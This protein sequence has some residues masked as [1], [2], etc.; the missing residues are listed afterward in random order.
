MLPPL[1]PKNTGSSLPPLPPKK[2]EG[3]ELSSINLPAGSPV[4]GS[5][6]PSTDYKKLSSELTAKNNNLNWVKRVT[7]ND[8]RFIQEP[9]GSKATH[10]L[11]WAEADGKI[12]VY[13][14]IVED[15]NGLKQLDEGEAFDYALSTKT[16]MEVPSKDIAQ[17]YSANGLIDHT[18]TP[19]TESPFKFSDNK[20]TTE[21]TTP[22]EAGST[23]VV[24][25]R[26]GDIAVMKQE[27]VKNDYLT[28]TALKYL[29]T[30]P[31]LSSISPDKLKQIKDQAINLGIP[32]DKIDEIY[33]IAVDKQRREAGLTKLSDK[34]DEITTRIKKGTGDYDILP[35]PGSN[36][37]PLGITP[38]KPT[39]EMVDK[40]LT[41]Y[42]T[43]IAIYE[44]P[45][46]KELYYINKEIERIE[47]DIN[48]TA[49][50]YRRRLYLVKQRQEL[51]GGARLFNPITGNFEDEPN[52]D[53]EK[54]AA[55]VDA[56]SEQLKRTPREKIGEKFFIEA[57]L[58][59]D[60][61]NQY[62][63]TREY[64]PEE[65]IKLGLGNYQEPRI[66]SLKDI[67]GIY[68]TIGM[69][70]TRMYKGKQEEE[71]YA[72]VNATHNEFVQSRKNLDALTDAYLL[73]ID[74]G[75]GNLG[76]L[77]YAG[78]GFLEGLE[79]S[80]IIG[81]IVKSVFGNPEMTDVQ[82]LETYATMA[83]EAGV[84]LTETQKK[85]VEN[86][87]TETV[88]RSGAASGPMMGDIVLS[89]IMLNA[90]GGTAALEAG[91]AKLALNATKNYGAIAGAATKILGEGVKTAITFEIAGAGGTTGVGE[92]IAQG[93]LDK[94][95]VLDK[96]TGK[97]GTLI[98]TLIKTGAGGLGETFG[99]YAGEFANA[100]EKNG[101]DYDKV[102]DDTFGK[103]LDEATKKGLA[104]LITSLLFSGTSNSTTAVWVAGKEWLNNQDIPNKDE[105]LAEIDKKI[106][107]GEATPPADI[108]ADV[109]PVDAPVAGG[110][111]SKNISDGIREILKDDYRYFEQLL[112]SEDEQE[113]S[114]ARRFLEDPKGYLGRRI[115][116]FTRYAEEAQSQS[117][118][119]MRDYYNG[120]VK[121]DKKKLS[122]INDISA[123]APAADGGVVLTPTEEI[124]NK[125][126]E[127]TTQEDTK[128]LA[129]D[130][131]FSDLPKEEKQVLLNE[132]LTKQE[133]ILQSQPV[134]EDGAVD[135]PAPI[136]E[137]VAPVE[138]VKPIRRLSTG[139]NVYF[140]TDKHRVNDD[141]KTGEVILNVGSKENTFP[142][143][144]IPFNDAADAVKIAERVARDF[145]NGVP[146]VILID[147]YIDGLKKELIGVT[148]VETPI[149]EAPVVEDG[150]VDIPAPMVE[151]VVKNTS[152]KIEEQKQK[153]LE[154]KIREL[155]DKRR[156][157]R[158]ADGSIPSD[159]MSEFK[160]LGTEINNAKK[161]AERGN[162]T[163]SMVIRVLP[164]NADF[165]T[166]DAEILSPSD[167]AKAADIIEQ[168]IQNS[169]TSDEA[170]EEIQ[171]L[172][173]VFNTNDAQHLKNYLDDRFNSK[174]PK[175]GNNK[176]SF[177]SWIYGK[178][179]TKSTEIAPA[180]TQPIETAPIKDNRVAT[181][182]PTQEPV[183]ENKYSKLSDQEIENRMGELENSNNPSDRQEFSVLEKEMEQR[184]WYS[185]MNK[186]LS[187]ADAAIDLLLQK[188]K[189]MPNGF[190][191]FI[192]KRDAS[193][194]KGVIKKYSSPDKI[195]NK[196]VLF[197]IYESM[198]ANP[199]T[200]YA[201]A[202]KLRESILLAIER[203]ATIEEIKNRLVT[204]LSN[205][206][207]MTIGMA[208]TI[209][210]ARIGPVLSAL[211]NE[212]TATTKA[213][214]IET[215]PVVEPAPVVETTPTK[216]PIPIGQKLE[217]R[218]TENGPRLMNRETGK[219]ADLGSVRTYEDA[220]IEA[221]K[222]DWINEGV[223][224]EE[225]QNRAA[226]FNDV[227]SNSTNPF[228]IAEAFV[229]SEAFPFE[230]RG[231]Y[232]DDFIADQLNGSVINKQSFIDYA[233][234]SHVAGLSKPSPKSK[235]PGFVFTEERIKGTDI[236]SF[237]ESATNISGVEITEEDVV[238]FMTTYGSVEAYLEQKKNPNAK[239]LQQKFK[240]LTGMP[241]N[242]KLAEKLAAQ[243]LENRG[244]ALAKQ[245]QL[246]LESEATNYEQTKQDLETYLDNNPDEAERVYAGEPITGKTIQ[247]EVSNVSEQSNEGTKG[248]GTEEVSYAEQTK[249]LA[250]EIKRRIKIDTKGTAGINI[251]PAVWN[252]AVDI[253]AS[254][255]ENGGKIADAIVKGIDY[256]KQTSAYKNATAAD[257]KS[258]EAQFKEAFGVF[259]DVKIPKNTRLTIDRNTG[260][261]RDNRA[262][263]DELKKQIR[264]SASV[265]KQVLSTEKER[266]SE[267]RNKVKEI[268]TNS[269]P[270]LPFISKKEIAKLFDRVAS[271][272]KD[273]DIDKLIN[274]ID[275][276]DRKSKE[277]EIKIDDADMAG[278][279]R[280]IKRD[281]K[282]AAQGF[283]QGISDTKKAGKEF[284]A[285][286]AEA[287]KPLGSKLNPS[288]I[289]A[290][291]RRAGDVSTERQLEKFQEYAEK[292]IAD[293]NYADNL[294][295]IAKAIKQLKRNVRDRNSIKIKE[296]AKLDLTELTVQQIS[297]L[298]DVL[299]AA[300]QRVPDTSLLEAYD[301]PV[302]NKPP[303]Q[304]KSMD[305]Y[306]E[307]RD[308]ILSARVYDLD[309]VR[310]VVRKLNTARRMLDMMLAQGMIS[311]AEYDSEMKILD[312]TQNL[313]S[314]MFKQDVDNA[315]RLAVNNIQT[316]LKDNWDK[317]NFT[318][319][320]NDFIGK[321]KSLTGDEMFNL[322]IGD[323]DALSD[324]S[325][326]IA[327]GTIPLNIAT[328][329]YGRAIGKARGAKVAEQVNEAAKK[330]IIPSDGQISETGGTAKEL[331]RAEAQ[332]VED[333]LNL[334]RG[335]AIYSYLYNVFSRAATA[336]MR[337]N[338]ALFKKYKDVAGEEGITSK[339]ILKV[340]S[341]VGAGTK[342]PKFVKKRILQ[343]SKVMMVRYASMVR[344]TKGSI[345]GFEI[346]SID[347][348]GLLL[349]NEAAYD[350]LIPTDGNNDVE[351]AKQ[352]IRDR[353]EEQIG[354]Y[355]TKR[356]GKIDGISQLD[357]MREVYE[358]FPKKSDGSVDWNAITLTPQE[359]KIAD[360][361]SEI[362][363]ELR[364][365]QR[366]AN[367]AKG[368]PFE[369]QFDYIKTDWLKRDSD[370]SSAE[371]SGKEG[372]R[373]GSSYV[374]TDFRPG[375][376]NINL[377][378]LMANSI[379][380]TNK[381][382]HF[383]NADMEIKPTLA[384]AGE[385]ITSK[386]AK[387]VV[388]V[389]LKQDL[390]ARKDFF[391]SKFSVHPY[392]RRL[393]NAGYIG[394][395]VNI[396]TRA[397][398][399]LVSTDK[400]PLLLGSLKPLKAIFSPLQRK[401]FAKLI[402]M[403]NS[404]LGTKLS[405][406]KDPSFEG[407]RS[408]PNLFER[409]TNSIISVDETINLV[410]A[411]MP[412]FT[413]EFASLAGEEFDMN[414]FVSDPDYAE[415]FRR[416]IE[417]AASYADREAKKIYGGGSK[418]EQRRAVQIF[419]VFRGLDADS[420]PGVFAA[421]LGSFGYRERT[422]LWQ[423]MSDMV[424]ARNQDRPIAALRAFGVIK[425]TVAYGMLAS[426]A[427]AGKMILTGMLTGD[428]EEEKKGRQMLKDLSSPEG[429]MKEAGASLGL[430]GLSK[431]GQA[432]R[433]LST[434]SLSIT[435]ANTKDKGTQELI[436][437]FMKENLYSRP[438]TMSKE[439]LI[440][441]GSELIPPLT[442]SLSSVFKM[443]NG[444]YGYGKKNPDAISEIYKKYEKGGINALTKT[445]Q[446][447]W[448]LITLTYNMMTLVGS[449][450]GYAPPFK[451]DLEKVMKSQLKEADKKR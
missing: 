293:A 212:N 26:T 186:P 386:K 164:K 49:E 288:Q 384:Y 13:P 245:E 281:A 114:S 27:K 79:N 103:D 417:D 181:I 278:L 87:L 59:E 196:E 340:G 241:L 270:R 52:A 200:W 39:P 349:G 207:N 316:N 84:N 97:Y 350:A 282:I 19:S 6:P 255:V 250:D 366:F 285:K 171:R 185:V 156:G 182:E 190:G 34:R 16:A 379:D 363:E 98:K 383:T 331:A 214:S 368:L 210:E 112:N 122:L 197:D 165:E 435:Y 274:F 380:E 244:L 317:E 126:A 22:I 438:I 345:Y 263:I 18:N 120:V 124:Q 289:K 136:V 3:T 55:E 396:S 179:D 423:A 356:D 414:K 284:A 74:P 151:E 14:T 234:V 222:Q 170:F 320:E 76:V 306:A 321:L 441:S 88:F 275:S 268:V 220:I 408:D 277:R 256:I 315:K 206:G 227:E 415:E 191:A 80:N 192:E 12:Y 204:G 73:N 119:V 109:P 116:S 355:K 147:K 392:I 343:K 189:D 246:F 155:E 77:D 393:M 297:E 372:T 374:R 96:V 226:Y 150:A 231:T 309:D 217:Y 283:R 224:V 418:F 239:G 427:Y 157:L 144:N 303:R 253:V 93:I 265:A 154:N 229:E 271:I 33:T 422:L 160:K 404:S 161:A 235:K 201:D 337:S 325:D 434:L 310:K 336:I 301:V 4:G 129:E 230:D 125:V 53:T 225:D 352:Q 391:N 48:S 347:Y 252:A 133:E 132:I 90:V 381:D 85:E 394:A 78:T 159:K 426:A 361:V 183:N 108:P 412:N 130:V 292:V 11:A 448:A 354:A 168:T 243:N 115:E 172:G 213:A 193:E 437:T 395:L 238:N 15:G 69:A 127:I 199:T 60:V 338:D 346:S 405:K 318:A 413:M 370:F 184:E 140:E 287:I 205:E 123:D 295:A 46:K 138:E 118:E 24:Q 428:E 249:K 248:E 174:A 300:N 32:A 267:I 410:G 101:F 257:R 82:K 66:L 71:L 173:Y 57:A 353:I 401:A 390:S 260:V 198:M 203:G 232:K 328:S 2:K 104:T 169:K 105:L 364:N 45:D 113:Q 153:Q 54:Y 429:I 266:I 365:K 445:E 10:K 41:K 377:D 290:L 67:Y 137:E 167:K 378:Q 314:S 385:G 433:Y 110:E 258:L 75:K 359:Q 5:V 334:G 1:P 106:A 439:G 208:N 450:F 342:V 158:L 219:P 175:I 92:G 128:K 8:K 215:T 421:Y 430:L 236:G 344:N 251:A 31:N 121:E 176:G 143:A 83:G 100:L 188:E 388:K 323:L 269:L 451:A 7:S 102:I 86:T 276:I 25:D 272:E 307:Y 327:N 42:A 387:D 218:E 149:A 134:V 195:S 141:L 407:K 163:Q 36:V 279:I 62:L 432:G 148:P 357:I 302:T 420:Y 70:D 131:M 397:I 202:I 29:A 324:V 142:A 152:D 373:A 50:D 382:Y 406:W 146:N 99:E 329:I 38:Q 28:N 389:T 261:K 47:N 51:G 178:N 56:I 61:Q 81:P 403:T 228:Q 280:Q 95:G 402:E 44:F 177:Q 9:D 30:V 17:Y 362:L 21:I 273:S 436:K 68:S 262:A 339:V 348:F 89:T 326:R 371:N 117:D 64:S 247:S 264:Y 58:F 291:V 332:S 294:A 322:N 443:I 145:P 298:N 162:S 425:A 299:A 240:D 242:A 308:E 411:W 367:E 431:Y 194:A 94:V 111:V 358:T 223:T 398:D 180:E 400:I 166:A 107:E 233:D 305:D 139:A 254:V 419:V 409:V 449:Q 65:M 304:A 312:D 399:T 447:K 424:L 72:K 341:W 416:E 37:K 335:R 296:I 211:K 319:E 376:L 63:E 237:A 369:E 221:K 216:E 360:V 375:A 43:N 313:Q 40:E 286:I 23:T 135:I 444:G 330:G 333:V 187:E 446:D 259:E 35:V 440:V 20:P 209:V 91:I 351:A 311:D 442:A